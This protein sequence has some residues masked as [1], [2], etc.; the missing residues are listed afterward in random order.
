MDAEKCVCPLL[1]PGADGDAAD[2]DLGKRLA[3]MPQCAPVDRWSGDLDTWSLSESD[4]VSLVRATATVANHHG[5]SAITQAFALMQRLGIEQA[6]WTTAMAKGGSMSGS[7]IGGPE[8]RQRW[9]MAAGQ[10]WAADKSG[11]W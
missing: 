2:S 3:A 9:C 6:A 5:R 7:V 11:L 4:Y 1:A 8:A 10:R